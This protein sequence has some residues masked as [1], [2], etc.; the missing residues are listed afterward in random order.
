MM[1]SPKPAH[2]RSSAT[3]LHQMTVWKSFEKIGDRIISC[4]QITHTVETFHAL[5]F[6]SLPT[7][8]IPN[9]TNRQGA[10]DTKEEKRG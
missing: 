9:L 10:K 3:S 6:Y 1:R 2:R 4:P 5:P 8:R 7:Q